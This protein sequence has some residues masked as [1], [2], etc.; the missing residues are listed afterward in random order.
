MFNIQSHT[1]EEDSVRKRHIAQNKIHSLNQSFRD[2][3]PD[4]LAAVEFVMETF[5]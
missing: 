3:T 5:D 1:A 2:D 4:L